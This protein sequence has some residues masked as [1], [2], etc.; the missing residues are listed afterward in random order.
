LGPGEQIPYVEQVFA[1]DGDW[2]T[3]LPEIDYV[4]VCL[5]LTP[6]TR[7]LIGAAEL[8][9]LPAHAWLVNVSRGAI[10]DEPALIAALSEQRIGGAALDVTQTEPLPPESPLWDLP[11][12]IL[13]PHISWQSPGDDARALDLFMENLRRYRAGE[14]LLNVVSFDMGY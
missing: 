1:Q 11:N 2:R 8:E 12:I 9:A 7:N 4:A 3:V 6:A 5:P 10:I 13:T 14:P